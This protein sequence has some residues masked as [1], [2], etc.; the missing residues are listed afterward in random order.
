MADN[1]FARFSLGMVPIVKAGC[2]RI[3]E[4]RL[5]FFE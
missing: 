2:Q 4:N 5:R 3:V 1:E